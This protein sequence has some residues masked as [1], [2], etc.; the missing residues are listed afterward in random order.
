MDASK[1]TANL[2]AVGL[3]VPLAILFSVAVRTSYTFLIG[4]AVVALIALLV[5]R[6]ALVDLARGPYR[7]PILAVLSGSLL[8][9]T[10][11]F[12][13]YGDG[14]TPSRDATLRIADPA[15][16]AGV[17]LVFFGIFTNFIARKRST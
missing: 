13:V 5:V 12:L 9:W 8:F 16:F 4:F 14:R 15:L 3:N 17:G 10:V 11:I 2:Y 6:E 7:L 1:H